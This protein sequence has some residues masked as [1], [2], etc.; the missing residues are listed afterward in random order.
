[1]TILSDKGNRSLIQNLTPFKPELVNPTGAETRSAAY[2]FVQDEERSSSWSYNNQ[3]YQERFDTVRGF[4]EEGIDLR[5]YQGT[6]G[7]FNYNRFAK[8]TG[9]VKTDRE[10]A[11]EKADLI[12]IR[13]QENQEIMAR[14]G[15]GSKFLGM[16]GSYMTDPLNYSQL[17]VPVGSAS[18]AVQSMSTLAK[19]LYYSRNVMATALVAETGIQA[20]VYQHKQNI[21][22]PYTTGD[23][24]KMIGIVTLSAGIFTVGLTAGISGVSS[25]FAK[26]SNAIAN[27]PQLFPRAPR[28]Y[29]SPLAVDGK[30]IGLPTLE[31]IA[32]LETKLLQDAR[33]DLLTRAGATI[34][35]GERKSLVAEL[36]I[37]A[38]QLDDADLP[39]IKYGKD[40]KPLAPKPVSKNKTKKDQ[41]LEKNR[42]AAIKAEKALIQGNID[43]INKV[44]ARDQASA[45]AEQALTR[46]EQNKTLP[47]KQQK[48]LDDYI[49]ANTTP[50][51]EA[52]FALSRWGDAMRTVKGP[53]V[54]DNILGIYGVGKEAGL[55][56]ATNKVV[57]LDALDSSIKSAMESTTTVNG[58][59]VESTG[60]SQLKNMRALILKTSD[61]DLEGLM[62]DLFRK[63][64]AEDL[65]LMQAREDA[66][67]LLQNTAL[68][69][70]DFVGPPSRPPPKA[71]A[72][73]LER[74]ALE[75]AGIASAFDAEVARYNSLEF[76]LTL[77]GEDIID[78]QTVIKT[79][80]EE[81]DQLEN[82]LRCTRG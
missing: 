41:K 31:N 62:T 23:A 20:A 19:S 25:Y 32:K 8:E 38:K 40:G 61:D 49:T 71:P 58:A 80:D 33:A 52:V 65:R 72:T 36:K 51:T 45:L 82:I 75:D 78:A 5:S 4:V 14:G 21:Q 1:M 15:G 16:A 60:L 73:S 47:A 50:E 55:D 67:N 70:E 10:L 17:L 34:A 12:S 66:F 13:R 46:I 76:K 27:Q 11:Q 6:N 77:D 24:I 44:L 30:P 64:V 59:V 35:R 74:Q 48:Q 81:L 9:L 37:L 68:K 18:V 26:S 56:A 79:L 22:S 28:A 53:T 57:M 54:L 43:R 39:E 63:N 3:M 42:Q 7:V 2:K 29:N 69:P